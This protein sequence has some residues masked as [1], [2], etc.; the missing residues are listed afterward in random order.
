MDVNIIA[1]S[2]ESTREPD[3]TV[4]EVEEGEYEGRAKQFYNGYSNGATND[5][6]W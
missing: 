2:G 5:V 4:V 6:T 1:T 3:L